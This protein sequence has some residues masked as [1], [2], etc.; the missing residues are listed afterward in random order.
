VAGTKNGFHFLEAFFSVSDEPVAGDVPELLGPVYR[1][2]RKTAGDRR[3]EDL[4]EC[5]FLGFRTFPGVG[6]LSAAGAWPA[7]DD[8]WIAGY[9]VPDE[10][11]ELASLVG[12]IAGSVDALESGCELFPLFDDRVRRAA[13]DGRGL[14]A[15]HGFL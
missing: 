1:Y 11:K 6:V 2:D 15:F 4:L 14:V 13:A 8:Y 12:Q 5:L 3:L 10:V 7:L 9:L